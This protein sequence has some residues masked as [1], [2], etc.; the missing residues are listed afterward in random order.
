MAVTDQG[1]AYAGRPSKIESSVRLTPKSRSQAH[2]RV[3]EVGA[4]EAGRQTRAAV[5][6][7]GTFGVVALAATVASPQ[8]AGPDDARVAD[9][10][11]L[12]AEHCAT[13][14]GSEG[15]GSDTAPP[16]VDSPPALVDFMLRTGRMPLPHAAARSIRR[17]PSLNAAERAAIVAYV[18]TFAPDE[19]A[20]PRV[21]P[22]AGDLQHG[23]EVYEANCIACHSAFGD[24]IAI[25]E[26]DIAPSL[27]AAAP[28]EIAEAV[29]AGPGV[30]PVF[31]RE[32]IDDR[33][34]NSLIRY[35]MFIRE[36]A[37]LGGLAVGRSGPVTEGFV[38]WTVGVAALLVAA[39]FIGERRRG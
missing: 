14:H 32:Q 37:N 5:V 11:R 20:I 33:D 29:R 3:G 6:V 25:S 27:H 36:H 9:G 19:P 39:Y 4:E 38:S 26:R 22:A 21:D 30:M 16:L 7:V 10:L 1:L 13:C 35:I 18:K 24:G 2:T 8:D 15:R 23:R 17:P 31:G 34:M 28:V 12:Y